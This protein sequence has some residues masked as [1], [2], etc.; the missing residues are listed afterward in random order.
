TKLA[1]GGYSVPKEID[2]EI[3]RLKLQ[4]MGITIDVLT[5]EQR[6][7]LESWEAGT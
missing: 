1:P 2:Q 6:R 7:Y 4:S 5:D 3:G